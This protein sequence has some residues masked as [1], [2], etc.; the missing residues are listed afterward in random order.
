M[1]IVG[2][3]VSIG[4]I[5]LFARI[6]YNIFESSG[7]K[8]VVVYKI[9]L[10][11]ILLV[12]SMLLNS[13]P[14]NL[15]TLSMLIPTFIGVLI[16]ILIS[17]AIEYYAYNKTNSFLMFLVY[18]FLIVIFI[19][20]GLTAILFVVMC[21]IE[22]SLLSNKIVKLILLIVLIILIIIIICCIIKFIRNSAV[23]CCRD[24]TRDF[25]FTLGISSFNLLR[26]SVS[27][28]STSRSFYA[29]TIS[30][31]YIITKIFKKI[32][33]FFLRNICWLNHVYCNNFR[34]TI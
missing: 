20:L 16:S 3:I 31:I 24:H 4:L 18:N 11:T 25:S 22:P 28:V 32:K 12:A 17:T 13:V 34:D 30:Y 21:F 2:L 26:F 7:F 29:L 1:G 6:E 10:E 19:V 15:I 9:V 14:I 27:P 5:L 33:K 23:A 8:G